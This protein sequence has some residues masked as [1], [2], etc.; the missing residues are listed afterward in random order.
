VEARHT[1]LKWRYCAPTPRR[2]SIVVAAT[3]VAMTGCS[4]KFEAD[5]TYC[6]TEAMEVHTPA[7][8]S[9]EEFAA[10]VR[11]CMRVEGWPI[12][13]ACLDKR[14]MWASSECYLR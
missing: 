12:R 7:R 9:T 4:D 3:V 5:L 8:V 2:H 6:K 13:D 14:H 10:Y 11:E 1:F